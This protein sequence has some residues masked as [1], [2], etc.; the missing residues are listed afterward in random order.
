MSVAAA[1]D[2]HALRPPLRFPRR[3]R[4]LAA[5]VAGVALLA[6][7]ATG[8]ADPGGFA[9]R[10]PSAHAAVETTATLVALLAG[11]LVASRFTRTRDRRDLALAAALGLLAFTNL[12]YR[13]VPAVLSD[14][15]TD[16]LIW[17]SSASGVL[18]AGAF[19]A[20]AF[21]RPGR[22]AAPRASALRTLAVGFALVIG[23]STVAAA[24]DAAASSPTAG[25]PGPD[26]SG[27][28]EVADHAVLVALQIAATALF[29][30]AAVYFVRRCRLAGDEVIGWFGIGAALA[31]VARL[32]YLLFPS[33]SLDYIYFGDFVRLAFY[34]VLL[35]GA[36]REIGRYQ[37]TMAR[38]A[39]LEERR[40]VARELHDGLA[41]DL[42]FIVSQTHALA[43]RNPGDTRIDHVAEAAQR[44]MDESRAAIVALSGRLDVPLHEALQ[45]AA[46]DVAGRA[47]ATLTL[48]LSQCAD[49]SA[50]TRH[51]LA[52]IVREATT[53]AIRHG[54]AK[55][56]ELSLRDAPLRVTV[57]DDGDG[58]DPAAADGEGF[59]LISMRERAD[60]LGADL[61]IE[62]RPG[63][64]TTVAVV[65]PD[66][67]GRSRD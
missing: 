56:I 10:N 22:L 2:P 25:S 18:S 37:R 26:E 42:A 12:V 49:V 20:A 60:A 61:R 62:S 54:R 21:I 57:R 5:T 39:S 24:L 3:I 6:T 66:A 13:T 29:A 23:V 30:V 48:D 51:A 27:W 4:A 33:F 43:R 19:A 17:A 63:A 41:Q 32:N 55:T 44:A 52:R 64:G 11:Y 16:Y 53:N 46:G 36:A 8:L 14:G 34:V 35:V 28:P 7:L 65:V 58:F 67:A 1:A 9:H 50:E 38:V 59:G 15:A 31:A 45:R 47:G 40:R